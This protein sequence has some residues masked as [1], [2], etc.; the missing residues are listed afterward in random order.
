[1]RKGQAIPGEGVPGQQVPRGLYGRQQ[2][3]QQRLQAPCNRGQPA[4]IGVE[5]HE[6][7]PLTVLAGQTPT[8][9]AAMTL[10]YST[11]AILF[12]RPNT[13]WDF[14]AFSR[15]GNVVAQGCPMQKS[16]LYDL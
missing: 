16:L 10:H 12:T 14:Q 9:A 1:M 7:P 4:W 6:L 13:V 11:E 8:L 15:L 3:R 2:L 5:G